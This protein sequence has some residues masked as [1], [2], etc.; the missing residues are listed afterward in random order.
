MTPSGASLG[1]PQVGH[2]NDDTFRGRDI[3][4]SHASACI[5]DTFA[6]EADGLP[7]QLFPIGPSDRH[8]QAAYSTLSG[9][10][11]FGYYHDAA[12]DYHPL[13]NQA[14]IGSYT[15]PLLPELSQVSPL[16]QIFARSA[17][18]VR[19]SPT[20]AT[21]ATNATNATTALSQ[22]Q[23]AEGEGDASESQDEYVP[24]RPS[25]A[26]PPRP[27]PA[28]RQGPRTRLY[29]PYARAVSPTVP[30]CSSQLQPRFQRTAP[31][32]EQFDGPLCPPPQGA[33][34]C[35]YCGMSYKRWCDL[36]RHVRTH[37]KQALRMLCGGLPEAE[38]IRVGVRVETMMPFVHAGVEYYGGC[39][40]EFSRKDS[41]SRHLLRS[42]SCVGSLT[43]EY[44][45]ERACKSGIK[46]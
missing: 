27:A 13:Q 45:L 42:R 33:T 21:N 1:L 11:S 16:V 17:S 14:P 40:K 23:D 10:A 37:S 6:G 32:N 36:D 28:R 20:K 22:E 44:N 41:L 8:D 30:P 25:R 43:T 4:T 24:S 7:L 39:M 3:L 38:A 2:I 31:R 15:S 12:D 5:W 46:K 35:E 29:A 34:D 18:P 26:R 9:D 19:A